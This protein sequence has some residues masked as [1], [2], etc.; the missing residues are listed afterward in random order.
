[1]F[2]SI[3]NMYSTSFTNDTIHEAKLLCSEAYLITYDLV[4]IMMRM[5][6]IFVLPFFKKQLI[7]DYEILLLEISIIC[8]LMLSFRIRLLHIIYNSLYV[9]C[10]LVLHEYLDSEDSILYTGTFRQV[11]YIVSLMIAFFPILWSLYFH[12]NINK[13]LKY[14]IV[15]GSMILLYLILDLCFMSSFIKGIF[16]DMFIYIIIW[17][18]IPFGILDDICNISIYM[19]NRFV[20]H[21]PTEN[22]GFSEGILSIIKLVNT[23]FEY[24]IR[25]NMDFFY[26]IILFGLIYIFVSMI[27]FYSIGCIIIGLIIPLYNSFR[28][29]IDLDQISLSK[30]LYIH[31][32]C[33]TLSKE[34][35]IHQTC[36][37]YIKYWTIY[38]IY[39]LIKNLYNLDYKHLELI[40]FIIVQLPKLE[41]G[42]IQYSIVEEVIIL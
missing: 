11:I 8:L 9:G 30:E 5:F 15:Y 25:L 18:N 34:L 6:E 40:F 17:I 10:C 3:S 20:I 4:Q 16:D 41:S 39:M 27:G 23:R 7:L 22:N 12:T 35:Y 24:M 36:T 19:M 1:M 21:V 26:T 14:C 29:S 38:F 2:T 37:R 28:V 31:Q 32:T 42:N 33:N 13:T